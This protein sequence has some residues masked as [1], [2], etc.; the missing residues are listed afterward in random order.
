MG[1][2]NTACLKALAQYL[3]DESMDKRKVAL[4]ADHWAMECVAEI[5]QQMNGSD[6]GMF[7]CKYAEY[8]ARR[9]KITF[10]QKDMP[11]FRRRMVYEIVTKT[12]IDP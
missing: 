7:A 4:A 10:T 3:N 12:L 8:I 6:C 5:P 9:S 11:Y 1:G 2:D